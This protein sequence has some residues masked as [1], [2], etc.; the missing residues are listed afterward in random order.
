M[1]NHSNAEK[2]IRK[3]KKRYARN[4]AEKSRMRTL[5]KKVRLSV[6]EKKTD[7]VMDHLR[8]AVSAL[9]TAAKK[10]VIHP[11]NASRKKSRLMRL[12]ANMEKE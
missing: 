2:S 5:I 9:D 10:H 3:D 6:A 7:E 11:S 1:P 12:V 8:L 4:V